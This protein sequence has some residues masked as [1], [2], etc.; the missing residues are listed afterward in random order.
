MSQRADESNVYRFVIEVDSM[1]VHNIENPSPMAFD[2]VAASVANNWGNTPPADG[3]WRY[4]NLTQY[5]EYE[6]TTTTEQPTTQGRGSRSVV[7]IYS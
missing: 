4:F 6:F 2:S 1:V 5:G 7:C 3:C